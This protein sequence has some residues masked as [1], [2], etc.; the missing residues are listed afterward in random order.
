MLFSRIVV[1]LMSL[2]LPFVFVS[3][4]LYALP[5][6]LC[7]VVGRLFECYGLLLFNAVVFRIL[8]GGMRR[9]SLGCGP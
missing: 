9:N 6:E 4:W 7:R 5:N 8:P 2:P 1:V 3:G